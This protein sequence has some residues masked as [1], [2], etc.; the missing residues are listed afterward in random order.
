MNS[1]RLLQVGDAGA[2][3]YRPN[4]EFVARFFGDNNLI[5]AKLAENRGSYCR[6]ETSAGDLHCEVPEQA[7]L[8]SHAAGQSVFVAIRPEAISFSC[9]DLNGSPL[10]NS[11]LGQVTAIDFNGPLTSLLVKLESQADEISLRIKT[12][13]Q[14][15]G[16]AVGTG[17]T[18]RIGWRS[19]DCHVVVAQ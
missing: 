14:R 16:L 18:I 6:V 7:L 11:F 19:A 3:Y 15:T 17:D 4:C 13:S 8:R 1:G 10:E 5:P 9:S 2:L 12:A